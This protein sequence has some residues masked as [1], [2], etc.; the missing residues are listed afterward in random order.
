M[1]HLLRLPFRLE[2]GDGVASVSCWLKAVDELS[3]VQIIGG[4]DIEFRCEFEVKSEGHSVVCAAITKDGM[5]KGTSGMGKPGQ[6]F[7]APE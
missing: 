3:S 2:V 7:V 1:K 6:I 5:N 4:M